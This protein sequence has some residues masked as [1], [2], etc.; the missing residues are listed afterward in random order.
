L[1]NANYI[2]DHARYGGLGGTMSN[3]QIMII[4]PERAI[5]DSRQRKDI[6]KSMID[7][8]ILRP[9]YDFG[10]IPGSNKP[11]LLKPGAERLC[12]AFGFDP[13]FETITSI[14]RWDGD[15]PLFFYRINCRLI[16]IE[17]GLEV[18]T[19]IGS[20]NSFESK[21]RWRWASEDSVA[22]HLEKSKLATRNATFTEFQFSVERAETTGKYAKSDEYWQRFK[23]EIAAGTARAGMRQTKNGQSP[24]W[25]IGGLEYRVPNDD[26]FSLVNTIDK[27][28]QKR[29]LIAA[30]LIGANASEFFTQDIEDMVGFGV[31]IAGETLPTVMISEVPPTEGDKPQP[32][33]V[34]P[35]SNISNTPSELSSCLRRRHPH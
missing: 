2:N 16:H 18:A 21:Y 17:T 28:A 13:R 23:D 34:T 24:T 1:K 12:S 14:E 35:S 5:Q 11:S 7:Q 19:G 27:M 20:C 29:A 26:I 3:H 9:N 25:E 4:D 32:I 30:T 31:D 33:P 10:V 6:V 8:S 15:E 22:P